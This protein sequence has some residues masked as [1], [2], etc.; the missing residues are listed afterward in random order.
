MS[1]SVQAQEAGRHVWRFFRA[2]GFDQ[3]NLASGADLAALDQLDQKLWVALSCPTKGLEFDSKTLDLIDTDKDGRIRVPEIIV[4]AKWA[5]ANLKNPDDLAKGGEALPLGA[6]N[7]AT[8]EGKQLL[9][10]ARRILASLGKADAPAISV[11]DTTDTA[12]VFA[13]TRFNGDGVV[14]ADAADDAATQALVV[15]IIA[16][17][18]GERDRSG[19]PGITQ[20]KVDQFFADLAAYSAWQ[21]QAEDAAGVVLPLGGSTAAAFDALKAV[22]AKVD[23]YFARCRL[24]AFDARAGGVLN[25]AEA[26]FA[27]LAAKDLSAAGAEVASFPLAKVEAG[28]PL[29][30]GEGVNPAWAGAIANLRLWAGRLC[31]ARGAEAPPTSSLDQGKASLTAE[32]WAAVTAK[33]APYEAW[34]GAKAGASVEKLGLPR[35]REILPGK[36]KEALTTLIAQDRALEPEMNAIVAVERLARYYRDLYQLLN[37]FVAFADFYS[38]QRKAVFQAGT[39]YLDGRSC[40]LCVR[41]DDMAKHGALASLSKTY[42]AYCDCTRK[43]S[44]EKMTIAAAFTGGDSDHLMVGRNGV[45]YDRKGQDWDATITK[46]V[47]HPI[48]IRQA[49][50]APY[51]RIARMIGEQIE[52]FAAARDK[53]VTDKAAAGIGDAAKA[54]EAPKPPAAPA[55]FDIAKFAG[56][57]AAIGLALG[58]IGTALAAVVSGFL[59]LTCWQMPLVILGIF[60]LISGPSVILAWLKLRQRDLGPILDASGWAVNAR[61]RINIPFGGALT[62]VAK[63]PPNAQ[64][65]L[66]DPYAQ[67][68]PARWLVPLLIVLALAGCVAYWYFGYY[69]PSLEKKEAPKVEAPKDAAPK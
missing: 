20:A 47:E 67:R 59:S 35:I 58:A 57:F 36:G 25:R 23:D 1:G 69:K 63:L 56:I 11:A 53:A 31:P 39:L 46:L 45:F 9:A 7:D 4:A 64:R 41:V 40:E 21:K 38:R 27:A 15:D 10:S 37:N 54:V 42:L 55:P 44:A 68:S 50:M 60:V 8:D 29:P 24:V 17:L 48:S 26:D 6:I 51:K 49:I 12:R 5:C 19:K 14:P 28:K 34:L 33:L 32:E 61:A 52:K 16:C 2:G 30:L 22:R 62:G 13:Q 65:S 66:V 43:G 18:G 3:V